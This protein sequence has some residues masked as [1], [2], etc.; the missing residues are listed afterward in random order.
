MSAESAASATPAQ[1]LQLP[2][3]LSSIVDTN[4]DG[5]VSEE[6]AAAFISQLKEK[7]PAAFAEIENVSIR[8]RGKGRG[9][10]AR[11]R[12]GKRL[13]LNLCCV[14]ISLSLFNELLNFNDNSVQQ[15]VL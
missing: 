4:K 2:E 15:K 1:G 6:E 14:G 12:N 13:T 9:K 5:I 8:K 11:R 3:G 7:N 10:D